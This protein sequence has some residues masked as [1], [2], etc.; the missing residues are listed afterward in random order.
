MRLVS[1]VHHEP[2]FTED[3]DAVPDQDRPL[4]AELQI[5]TDEQRG[6]S[7]RQ[8]ALLPRSLLVQRQLV[9]G[10]TRLQTETQP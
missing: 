1:P 4:A 6:P 10:R 7:Q 8:V 5:L 3:H 9:P 2:P